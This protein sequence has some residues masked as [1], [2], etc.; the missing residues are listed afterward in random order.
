MSLYSLSTG[1]NRSA[2]MRKAWELSRNGTIYQRSQ[3]FGYFLRRAWNVARC[4]KAGAI[5]EAVAPTL[6]RQAPV[7]TYE[8]R[9]L[10][11][12]EAD[13]LA[14]RCLDSTVVSLAVQAAVRARYG[15]AA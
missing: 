7:E 6:G 8:P 3:G 2:I 4:A 11:P 14:A 15:V 12:Y 1:F 13:M 9:P 5:R 10:S